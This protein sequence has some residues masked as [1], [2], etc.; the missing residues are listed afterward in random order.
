MAEEVQYFVLIISVLLVPKLLLRFRIPTALT[1]M[2]MGIAVAFF[3]GWFNESQTV[4]TLAT[5]GIT[6]LFLFAGFEVNFDELKGNISVLLK[7]LAKTSLLIALYSFSLYWA[8]ELSLRASV[9][10]ALG[11]TTPSTGFILSSLK[12]FSFTEKQRYWIR[13]KAISKE[14]LALIILF[15]ALQSNSGPMLGLSVAAIALI[16]SIVPLLFYFFLKKIAPF[17]PDSEVTFMILMA[18]VCGV[19]TKELGTYYLIGAFIVGIVAGQFSHF[20][21]TENSEKMLYSIRFFSSIF[22]PFYF[23]KSGLK[24]NLEFLDLASL[25]YGAAFL[26]I[27]IPLRY[28]SLFASIYFFLRDCWGSRYEITTSLMPTLIFGLVIASI[29]R[30]KLG[31]AEEIVNGLIIYTIGVSVIPAIFLK[32]SPPEVF[33]SSLLRSSTK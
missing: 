3:L 27:F 33:D 23:F 4:E 7:Q 29:L 19:A 18:F 24:I 26:I 14:V 17:A 32:S 9:L 28:L 1:E 5:L 6:S 16:I 30:D 20:I 2:A 25:M 15:F 21:A 10:L 22:V 13:T 31:V 8:L 12:G 11:F